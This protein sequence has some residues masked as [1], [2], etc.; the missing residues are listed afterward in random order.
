MN[1]TTRLPA[2]VSAAL[3]C[4]PLA[5]CPAAQAQQVRRCTA[6]D[7]GVVM[8]DQPCAAIG[9]AERLPPQ[10]GATALERPNRNGCMRDLEA[11]SFEV[12][13]AIDLRDANR[14]AGV[15]HWAGIDTRGGYQVMQRLETIVKRPLVD[16]GPVGGGGDAEP[17]WAG[18]TDGHLASA[19]PRKRAPSG[20]RILQ[21]A[22][23]DGQTRAIV[24]ALRRHLGCLWISL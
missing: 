1:R 8:T 23:H 22:G 2:L 6:A 15:Y 18:D 21:S 19:R 13:A 5:A 9:A 16:I 20:L 24:F 12:A 17:T 10:A 7:G 14:L 3:L 4:L 11:L